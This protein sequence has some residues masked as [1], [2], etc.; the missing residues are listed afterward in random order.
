MA[1]AQDESTSKHQ[2]CRQPSY[3]L[4]GC[5]KIWNPQEP[6]VSA[7][8]NHNM[9]PFNKQWPYNM[10]YPLRYPI[11]DNILKTQTTHFVVQ[12]RP[13]AGGCVIPRTSSPRTR[14]PHGSS[15]A[16][17]VFRGMFGAT[18][19]RWVSH[20]FL[21]HTHTFFNNSLIFQPIWDDSQRLMSF[22]GLG[23]MAFDPP[24]GFAPNRWSSIR[25]AS[26][27]MCQP[28]GG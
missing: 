23:L 1:A 9:L 20:R 19:F 13:V 26:Q 21:T 25:P 10:G 16:R 27:S 8:E 18:R 7:V 28:P 5:F 14:S 11:S 24:R 12:N 15:Q 2:Q 3:I 22:S 6:S 17:A 4:V